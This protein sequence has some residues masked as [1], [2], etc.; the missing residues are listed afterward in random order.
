[1]EFA[2]KKL[3]IYTIAIMVGVVVVWWMGMSLVCD[4]GEE[5]NASRSHRPNLRRRPGRPAASIDA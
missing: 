2:L 4:G 5:P 1:M 3:I